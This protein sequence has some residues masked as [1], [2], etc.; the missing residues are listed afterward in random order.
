MSIQ[1]EYLTRIQLQSKQPGFFL[2]LAQCDIR[3]IFIAVGVSARLQP[4]TQLAVMRQQ[5]ARTVGVYDKSRSSEMS[6]Q[7]RTYER[8]GR[9]YQEIIELIHGKVFVRPVPP[10][11]SESKQ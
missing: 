10:V 6:G 2:C 7:V 1:I 5:H 3:E 9:G 8:A 11:S 4:T